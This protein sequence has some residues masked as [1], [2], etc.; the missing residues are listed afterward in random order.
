MAK[1]SSASSTTPHIPPTCLRSMDIWYHIAASIDPPDLLTLKMI[2]SALYRLCSQRSVWLQAAHTMCCS[3][4]LFLPSFPFQTMSVQQ[5]TRLALS[6][7]NFSRL[8]STGGDE[9]LLETQTRSFSPRLRRSAKL[10]ELRCLHLVPGGRFLLTYHND[11]VCL[12]DLG[13]GQ[14]L[15]SPFPIASLRIGK[16]F[17]WYGEKPPCPTEDGKGVLMLVLSD[18]ASAATLEVY[19]IYPSSSEPAFRLTQSWQVPAESF[20]VAYSSQYVVLRSNDTAQIYAVRDINADG[21][22]CQL[23]DI[24][25]DRSFL[26]MAI[27][28]DSV[29]IW[30]DDSQASVKVLSIPRTTTPM[31]VQCAPDLIIPT[32][33]PGEP[34]GLVYTSE[35]AGPWTRNSFFALGA[36]N[37]HNT[38]ELHLYQMVDLA[39]LSNPQLPLALPAKVGKVSITNWA[40]FIGGPGLQPLSSGFA[41]IG[42][43][44]GQLVVAK[45]AMS[46]PSPASQDNPEDLNLPAPSIKTLTNN[47]LYEENDVFEEVSACLATG[48]LVTSNASTGDGGGGW[49]IRVIDYL[50]LA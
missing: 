13:F 33:I 18:D 21:P 27:S 22:R 42:I 32:F 20:L 1:E 19:E 38:T 39:P 11:A 5:L 41:V 48:R 46:R 26:K 6:P 12:W 31:T 50:S 2:C 45:M 49:M 36:D 4:G 28:G 7:F 29:I 3:H 30:E 16:S 8:V 9:R 15:P 24:W 14:V 35:W 43:S 40:Y 37:S 47:T 23:Q 17:T 10:S 34:V 25:I 44:E